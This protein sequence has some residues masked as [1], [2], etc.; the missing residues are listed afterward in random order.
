MTPIPPGTYTIF[1]D[2]SS[3]TKHKYLTFGC[4]V[5][6]NRFVSLFERYITHATALELPNGEMKWTKVSAAKLF[7]YKLVIDCFFDAVAEY[8]PLHFHAMAVDTTKR[9]EHVYNGGSREL[10]FNKEVYQ[11]LFKCARLYPE[12]LF[13]VYADHRDTTSSLDELQTILNNGCK[14]TA[15]SR[16]LP[17][18]RI[19]F[20]DSKEVLCLQMV[21]LLLGA[22]SHRLNGHHLKE[23]SSPSKNHLSQYVLNR[24]QV[25]DAFRDTRIKDKYTI[26]HRKLK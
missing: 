10:G 24:A 3:Q 6:D 15:D 17:F 11:L 13:H 12:S 5:L 18:R 8:E 4:L 20:R 2:E 14:K 9:K 7:A 19:Q 16:P 21:D 26:W 22:V 1:L 23:G 25:G